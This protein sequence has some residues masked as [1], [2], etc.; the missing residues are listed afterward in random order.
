MVEAIKESKIRI[1]SLLQKK[2]ENNLVK[3]EN[4]LSEMKKMQA[5]NLVWP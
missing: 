4:N 1:F 2:R 3:L 5:P